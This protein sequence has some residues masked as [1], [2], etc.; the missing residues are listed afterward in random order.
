MSPELLLAAA[1]GLLIAAGMLVWILH[2]ILRKQC[3]TIARM[4]AE[5]SL[6]DVIRQLNELTDR[7]ETQWADS[8][9]QSAAADQPPQADEA[10]P[11]RPP[12]E[13][14]TDEILRLSREGLDAVE[15]ARRTGASVGEAELVMNLN[16]AGAAPRQ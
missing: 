12:I 9:E 7:I 13:S 6:P 8:R 11:V 3:Q 5:Q 14:Q 15:I 4:T 1:A 16:R 2:R 10:E